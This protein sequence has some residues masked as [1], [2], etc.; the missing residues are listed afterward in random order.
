M[1]YSKILA[2]TYMCMLRRWRIPS[3]SCEEVE[4]TRWLVA[5]KTLLQ[6]GEYSER[7]LRFGVIARYPLVF[8]K[9]RG[10]CI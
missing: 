9:N 2:F 10:V 8:L 1:T 3:K 6:Y 5:I 7:M 4:I